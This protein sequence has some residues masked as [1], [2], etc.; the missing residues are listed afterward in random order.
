M[1][2][3]DFVHILEYG[4]YMTYISTP[5]FFLSTY[6]AAMK[7]WGL[8]DIH[9][10]R[11]SP[12]YSLKAPVFGHISYHLPHDEYLN[13]YSN[14]WKYPFKHVLI[15]FAKKRLLSC[16]RILQ[17]SCRHQTVQR[18]MYA[19]GYRYNGFTTFLIFIFSSLNHS[20]SN[21][22]ALISD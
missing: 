10:S 13:D 8:F 15:R 14:T 16:L 18:F 21:F 7:G 17:F 6:I 12:S 5:Q 9:Q 20:I 22:G 19:F 1:F 3:S 2:R 4:S 11:N